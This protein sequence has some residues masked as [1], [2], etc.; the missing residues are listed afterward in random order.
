LSNVFF[1]DIFSALLE[2]DTKLNFMIDT[3][4]K[5]SG[6]SY[7][8]GIECQTGPGFEEND[9]LFGCL[10]ASHFVDVLDVVLADAHDFGELLGDKIFVAFHWKLNFI[11]LKN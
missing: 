6:Q 8:F 9:R 7:G 5:G 2:E 10:S 3:V 4:V 11:S 1:F